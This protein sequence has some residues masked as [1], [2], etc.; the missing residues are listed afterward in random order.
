[1]NEIYNKLIE[2]IELEN[3]FLR[4]LNSERFPSSGFNGDIQTEVSVA[5]R[6]EFK[7]N[8]NI[9]TS[10]QFDVDAFDELN[11]ENK[12]FSIQ[13]IFILEYRLENVDEDL[14]NSDEFAQAIEDFIRINV[15]LNA[16]PYGREL[17]SQMTTRMGLPQLV[18][19]TYKYIPS[20]KLNTE[21]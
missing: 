13:S 1:M 21:E 7:T 6:M 8:N 15:P 10:V 20:Q 9:V 2:A 14:L 12:L 5:Q 16:W 17:I 4:N 18:I 11:K 3:I 19:G